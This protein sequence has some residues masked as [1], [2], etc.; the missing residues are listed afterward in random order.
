MVSMTVSAVLQVSL[1]TT[2][3]NTYADAHRVHSETGRP[4]VVLVGAEW[5][6]ACVQMKKSVLPRVAR[7]LLRRVAFA[8]INT[9]RDERLAK[10][11]M[12][13]GS[14]PQLVMYRRTADGWRRHML[15]GAQGP[16]D[17]ES[18]INRGLA[19]DE[20]EGVK[21]S[22]VSFERKP[23]EKQPKARKE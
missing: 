4:M 9:D 17:V 14:I 12:H 16:E 5:C 3:A 7:G 15:V 6:P 10:Q 2:G 23:A 18:F 20:A 21:A 8:Q 1:L 11:I 13:G 22:K 19:L